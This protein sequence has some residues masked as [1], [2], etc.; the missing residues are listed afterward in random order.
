MTS[1]TDIIPADMP[2]VEQVMKHK[3]IID[4]LTVAIFLV[5]EKLRIRYL[6]PAAEEFLGTGSRHALNHLLT[7]FIQDSGDDFILRIRQSI[8]ANHPV[9]EREVRVKRSGG[10]EIMIN[11]SISPILTKRKSLECL[12][13]ITQVDW[14][15]RIT[16]EE[17]LLAES[18][19]TQNMLRGLAHEIKNPLGGLRGAAQLLAGELN[20]Q[21]L[22]EYTDVI[23]SEADRLRKLV[24][25]M[26]GPNVTPVKR[27][28]NIHDVL[29][30]IRYLAVAETSNEI[31]FKTDYDPSIPNVQADRDLLVQAILNL[32]RNAIC[33]VNTD[34]EISV[35][36]RVLR[37]Y[38][39]GDTLHRLVVR[40]SI[41]D[42]GPGISEALKP[43]IFFPMVSGNEQGTGLGLPIAQNLINLHGGLIEF[44]SVP[45]LTE[46]HVLLPLDGEDYFNK[47][48]MQL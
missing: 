46:F 32:V 28:L 21:D 7:D 44:D 6:N 16:R 4:N 18:Q 14:L 30:H 25:R 10:E 34:G 1:A 29:E 40:I 15:L 2:A 22:H 31:T 37:Q 45:G 35:K 19:A 27:E 42:N 20:E 12:L 5:N 24:D 39:L 33:A 9:T 11:C 17:H 26:L 38:T 8:R 36:T 43:Q 13:E 3:N 41:V 48:K 23:I 47:A